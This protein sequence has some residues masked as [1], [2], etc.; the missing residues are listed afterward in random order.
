[1]VDLDRLHY[2][3]YQRIMMVLKSLE[4]QDIPLAVYETYRTPERQDYLFAQGRTHPGKIVTYARSWESFHQ[5]GLA[6]DMAFKVNG[7]WTWDEPRKGMWEDYH[8]IARKFHLMPL[9]FETPHIQIAGYTIPQLRE[10]MPK[11]GGT[12]WATNLRL[13]GYKGKIP[14]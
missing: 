3:V 14:K 7:Q 9:N 2:D 10:R 4:V 12:T 6:V 8:R 13:N 5:Y 1:M 11:S